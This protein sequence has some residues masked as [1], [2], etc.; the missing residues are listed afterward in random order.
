MRSV[1][2]YTNSSATRSPIAAIRARGNR[3]RSCARSAFMRRFLSHFTRWCYFGPRLPPAVDPEPVIRVKADFLFHRARELL[4]QVHDR[5]VAR[6]ARSEGAAHLHHVRS[7][8]LADG[9][10]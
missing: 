4:G 9:E 8:G 3:S 2:P 6:K 10:H 1:S 7:V 5:R